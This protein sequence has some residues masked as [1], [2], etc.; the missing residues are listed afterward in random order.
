MEFVLGSY[1]GKIIWSILVCSILYK[2]HRKFHFR[3]L[4]VVS[5]LFKIV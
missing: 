2:V 4:K 5:D 1:S 3:V